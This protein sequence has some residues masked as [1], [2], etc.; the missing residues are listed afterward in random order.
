MA[1][2]KR[3]AAVNDFIASVGALFAE[4][5]HKGF[6]SVEDIKCLNGR[7]IKHI[8]SNKTARSSYKPIL[9]PDSRIPS[10]IVA[11]PPGKLRVEGEN[12]ERL[13]ATDS[14]REFVGYLRRAL[15]TQKDAKKRPGD[16]KGDWNRRKR[17]RRSRQQR[18]VL[19]SPSPSVDHGEES[20]A[21][22]SESKTN[23][24]EDSAI[25]ECDLGALLSELLKD[26][27]A[28]ASLMTPESEDIPRDTHNIFSADAERATSQEPTEEANEEKLDELYA[29]RQ[30]IS[31]KL[32]VGE[33]ETG[34]EERVLR[35]EE[36]PTPETPL[37]R[38][39]SALPQ[40][41]SD[42]A[43]IPPKNWEEYEAKLTKFYSSSKAATLGF[44]DL[45]SK[46]RRIVF[47]PE[48]LEVAVDGDWGRLPAAV[49]ICV[50]LAEATSLEPEDA[51]QV[52]TNKWVE[53]MAHFIPW[54]EKATRYEAKHSI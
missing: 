13:K 5:E 33:D 19:S 53:E 23:R 28:Q 9:F 41:K 52:L 43:Q 22:T 8:L 15:T 48:E 44:I 31:I 30:P 39:Q 29:N 46:I 35:S 7:I 36:S 4:A 45:L 10:T 3:T 20:D 42:I 25:Q 37:Q 12:L 11:R 34:Q 6:T 50:I 21:A 27:G 38:M 51:K 26:E 18:T 14:Y 2:Q 32:K 54:L 24:G 49:N 47:L 17:A 40:L 16:W 1:S